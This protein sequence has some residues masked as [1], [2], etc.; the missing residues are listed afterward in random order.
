MKSCFALNCP[1]PPV[2]SP[3]LPSRAYY[4]AWQHVCSGLSTHDDLDLQFLGHIH[5]GKQ[6]W[7]LRMKMN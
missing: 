7:P 3:V 2:R 5:A 1:S 6:N 4:I